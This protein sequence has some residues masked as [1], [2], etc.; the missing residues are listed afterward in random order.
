MSL[1]STSTLAYVTLNENVFTDEAQANAVIGRLE[2]LSFTDIDAYLNAF[3]ITAQEVGG[4]CI[5]SMLP[6]SLFYFQKCFVV[7][8]LYYVR[9]QLP[10]RKVT[11]VKKTRVPKCSFS[12][13]S[14]SLTAKST[15]QGPGKVKPTVSLALL[16]VETICSL[17]GILTFP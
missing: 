8:I 17:T 3:Q 6:V 16:D 10:D 5:F 9:I 4:R 12:I 7:N 2:Q 14:V 1:L 13:L 11:G 15:S